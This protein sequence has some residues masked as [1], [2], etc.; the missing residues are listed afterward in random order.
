M[1][2]LFSS[3]APHSL[4]GYGVQSKHIVDGLQRMG[5]DVALAPNYGLQGGAIEASGTLIYPLYREKVGQD[6]IPSHARHFGAELVITLYDLWPYD[7]EFAARLKVPWAPYFPQDCYPP[8]ATVVERVKQADY[9]IA[10]SKFGVSSLAEQGVDCHYVPHGVDTIIYSP[11]DKIAARKALREK[12][13][14]GVE[15]P[16]DKYVVLMVAANQSFP[17]RKAFPECLSGFARFHK[18][19][20]ESILYLHT[21][22]MPRGAAWDGIELDRLT[23]ALGIQ[24]AVVF[25]DEYA[26]LLGLTSENMAHVYNSADVLLSASMGEG[27]G[28]PIIEAQ[29]SG[30]PVI[31]TDFSAMSE[32]TFNGVKLKPIQESWTAINTWQALP[33]IPGIHQAL[34]LLYE[35]PA[36]DKRKAADSTRER[37]IKE[38]SWPVIIEQWRILLDAI[39]RGEKPSPERLYHVDIKGIEFD[40]LEDKQSYT[41]NAVAMELSNN[42]YAFDNVEIRPGDVIV[43]IGAHVGVF[44]IYAAKKYPEAKILAF[45]PSPT[46][47]DRLRRNLEAA[48][49]TNVTEHKLAVTADGR[50]IE[51]SWERGNTGG[52]TAL[53]K[54]NGH[55][56]EEAKSCT[57][58]DIFEGLERIRFL[59]IDAEGMEHEIL[60]SAQ[61]LD[62][63]D[64]LSG[65]FHTNATLEQQGHSIPELYQHLKGHIP[66]ERITYTNCR[67]DD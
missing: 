29:A 6:V 43:D 34:N 30:I 67:I 17:S 37:I 16:D 41:V 65:E 31:T 53:R 33:P 18:E 22:K 8:C 27:F 1:K 19:H 21:T 32:I 11:G 61:C 46:N 3:N 52:T 12:G 5:H 25:T 10:M 45:E 7:S 23:H 20:P 14:C 35:Q 24:D 51:L 56:V 66:A 36:E 50:D 9:P 59:K 26:L 60:K 54:V 55:L 42:N 15:I 63:I 47:F 40:A 48:G 58:D 64:Y 57:L 28:V 4:S 2:I 39:E 38:Y 62:R 49:V 13:I 44:S